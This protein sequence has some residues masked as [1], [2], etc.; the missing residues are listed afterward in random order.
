MG[1]QLPNLRIIPNIILNTNKLCKPLKREPA[2]VGTKVSIFCFPYLNLKVRKYQ[3]A[4]LN[5]NG[6]KCIWERRPT[7]GDTTTNCAHYPYIPCSLHINQALVTSFFIWQSICL[8]LGCCS[9]MVVSFHSDACFFSF[10][11]YF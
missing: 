2:W 7:E 10:H 8:L 11:L 3:G 4:L 1:F 9:A 5:F 6:S